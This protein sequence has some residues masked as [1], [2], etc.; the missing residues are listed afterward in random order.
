M[1]LN[2][3]ERNTC[4]RYV[5]AY[6]LRCVTRGFFEFYS[7]IPSPTGKCRVFDVKYRSNFIPRRRN[8]TGWLGGKQIDSTFG[9]ESTDTSPVWILLISRSFS[10]SPSPRLV[11]YAQACT[12]IVRKTRS[13]AANSDLYSV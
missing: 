3:L 13:F 5:H 7:L 4:C 9:P 12:Y 11:T 1:Q 2:H 8:L 6:I 10:S